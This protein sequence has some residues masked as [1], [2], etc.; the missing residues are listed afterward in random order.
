[1]AT[2]MQNQFKKLK[3]G[4]QDEMTIEK[5]EIAEYVAQDQMDDLKTVV[6]EKEG[7]ETT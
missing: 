2:Q 6:P 5:E 4:L 1:M 7:S 3:I